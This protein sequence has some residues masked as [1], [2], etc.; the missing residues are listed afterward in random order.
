M[1]KRVNRFHRPLIL[2]I[3][4]LKIVPL[5][6]LEGAKSKYALLEKIN[7]HRYNS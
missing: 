2:T 4:I 1:V 3:T 5:E 6:V 7:L